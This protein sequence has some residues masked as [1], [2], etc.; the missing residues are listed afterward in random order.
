MR[1]R[2]RPVRK[3]TES[4]PAPAT[5]RRLSVGVGTIGPVRDQRS[6]V[7]A[8]APAPVP[9]RVWRVALVVVVG[10]FMTQLD[11]A[12]TN[13]GLATIAADLGAPLAVAQWTVSGYLLGLV[14]GLPLAGWAAA[15]IGAGRLWL[16]ALAAFTLTSVACAAAPTMGLLVAARVAQGVAGGLLLPAG[17]TVI[18]QVAGRAAMGRVMSTVGLP[19]VLGPALGPVV[20]GAVLGAGGWPWL[21]WVNVPVGV[22]GLWLGRRI[23]PRERP[24]AGSTRPFDALGFVLVA[25]GL[26]ALTYAVS[27][28]GAPAGM[29][30]L[31]ASGI[32]LAA[33]V[34]FARRSLR[35]PAPLLD[36]RLL[37]RPVVAAAGAT[38]L[39]VGALQIGALV[40]WA[41]YFQ[42][43][44]GFTPVQAGLALAGF[45]VGSALLPL[46]GRLTDRH[47]G[48][49]VS[50]AGAVL[51]VVALLGLALLP[52]AAPLA[53]VEAVM[54]V[55][56]VANAMSVVPTSTAAY[57]TLAPAE[58]PD[59]VTQ[60][61]VLLRLGGAVGAALVVTTLD[62]AGF[63]AAWWALVV[64]AVA[65]AATATWLLA[66]SR[67]RRV[68]A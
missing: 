34:V 27:V 64:T 8:T 20:G 45:A 11:A 57:V 36:L 47:G 12:L 15:R 1:V 2:T 66:A 51:T 60:I 35:V 38:S 39:L 30:F 54:V 41:L 37:A 3:M 25:G 5:R 44:R 31:A 6:P 10:A 50:A 58:I 21:F 29:P 7:A 56:G 40:L 9:W 48:A 53:A 46:A 26:P 16:A 43:A 17:Q 32:G 55:F 22:V 62:A 14:G 59:A 24:A 19:L 61:N 4:G 68:P 67:R 33:L 49:V 65:A 13:I 42:D 18:A 63:A 52:A 28:A 23:V